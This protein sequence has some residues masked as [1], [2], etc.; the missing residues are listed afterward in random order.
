MYMS[1]LY[2]TCGDFFFGIYTCIYDG[3][4]GVVTSE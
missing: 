1:S 4:M 3:V 2:F